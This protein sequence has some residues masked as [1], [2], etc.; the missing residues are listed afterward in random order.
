MNEVALVYC[1]PLDD[2]QTFASCAER[3]ANTRRRYDPAY[4]HDLH[5]AFCNGNPSQAHKDV[6]SG[7]PFTAHNIH[8]TGWDIG[9]YQVMSKRLV[10]YEFVVFMNARG[11]FW[12]SGWLAR[13]M[14]ARAERFDPNGLYGP[15]TS[16]EW[17]YLGK[18]PTKGPTPHIR[19][20]C[21]GT[22]PKTFNRY[23]YAI[24][25]REHGFR[26]ESGMWNF[27]QWYEDMG[28]TVLMVTWDGVY[29]KKDWRKPP[30]IF[31]RGDQSNLLVCDRHTEI[32]L[33]ARADERKKL[34]ASA[35]GIIP[36][37]HV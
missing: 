24:N 20:A 29:E 33:N 32:Y 34:E 36:P 28:Y 4:P 10:G 30:N 6:F 7:I 8:S 9:T 1:F 37:D 5:I 2:L 11:H 3:W 14:A 12:R 26:F 25:S 18:P 27:S 16:Y 31:R 22:N 15:S 21:F 13:L 35:N 17:C 23:P 19:T